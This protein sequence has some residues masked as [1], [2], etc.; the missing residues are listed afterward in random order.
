M[1]QQIITP[2]PS[3]MDL[4][5]QMVLETEL[6]SDIITET[7]ESAETGQILESGRTVCPK[8]G[9]VHGPLSR[10]P[11]SVE[12]RSCPV[13][14][15]GAWHTH[16][17]ED[18][19]LNPENSIPDIG[20]VVFDQLDVIAVAGTE[21][22][23]YFVAPDDRSTFLQ[24]FN[25]AL[26]VEVHTMD[27]LVDVVQSREVDLDEAHDRIRAQFSDL[28]FRTPTGFPALTDRVHDLAPGSVFAS[29]NY[30]EA[31]VRAFY[32]P[33]EYPMPESVR[34]RQRCRECS[35]AA[36]TTL[37]SILPGG[38]EIGS[39]ATGAAVGTVVGTLVERVLFD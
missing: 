27:E 35:T 21:T 19:L 3:A 30:S 26:G 22:A 7:L 29:M 33:A 2:D 1:D 38:E 32:R 8:Q 16:V 10:L 36:E 6:K 9:D 14:V 18:E 11:T 5:D 34:F 31:E 4:A 17:T 20:T 25:D 39:T 12:M 15:G 23:E 28:F 24:E 13:G 37:K